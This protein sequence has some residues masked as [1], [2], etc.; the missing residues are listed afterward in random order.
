MGHAVESISVRP[1]DR[2]YRRISEAPVILA[3]LW[4]D[5]RHRASYSDSYNSYNFILI[6]GAQQTAEKFSNFLKLY[7]YFASEAPI[8]PQPRS[9]R[10]EL[11]EA[12]D[13]KLRDAESAI[14]AIKLER[15]LAEASNNRQGISALMEEEWLGL[16]LLTQLRLSRQMSVTDLATKLG[17]QFNSV[18]AIMARLVRFGV[19]DVVQEKFV[20]TELADELLSNIERKANV[21]LKE[22]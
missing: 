12:Y 21:S 17:A 20:C 1:Q 8:F 7:A 2:P 5:V 10:P 22:E 19:V 6:G 4:F 16:R 3:E 13:E 18:A 9:V 15:T 14:E 11:V